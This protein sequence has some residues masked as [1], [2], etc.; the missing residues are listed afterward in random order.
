MKSLN[1]RR[2]ISSSIGRCDR[3]RERIKRVTI[4][5]T[6]R[7]VAEGSE[8]SAQQYGQTLML[9]TDASNSINPQ[10]AHRTRTFTSRESLIGIPYWLDTKMCKST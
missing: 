4:R 2:D 1:P 10:L 5:V 8:I 6:S 3:C 9:M 7:S